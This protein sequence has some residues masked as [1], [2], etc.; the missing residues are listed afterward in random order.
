MNDFPDA[1]RDRKVC[2]MG[3]GYMGLTL[4]AVMA[5]VGFTVHGVEIRENVVNDLLNGQ[6]HFHGPAWLAGLHSLA[7]RAPNCPCRAPWADN[8]FPG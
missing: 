6:P 8:S 7:T 5:H 4:A 3:L 1:S 2:V